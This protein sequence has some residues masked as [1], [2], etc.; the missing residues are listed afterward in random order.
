[1]SNSANFDADDIKFL[2]DLFNRTLALVIAVLEENAF[3][4][5]QKGKWSNQPLK[6]VYDAEMVAFSHFI[7]RGEKL[8][9]R[10]TQILELLK[11]EFEKNEPQYT[12]RASLRSDIDDRIKNVKE[13][14][15]RQF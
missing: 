3:R 12:G 15:E 2:G 1:M 5:F 8:I 9:S 11:A 13:I 10:K 6:G 4:L 14:L 7:D